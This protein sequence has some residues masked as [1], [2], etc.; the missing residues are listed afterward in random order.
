[1]ASGQAS[2]Q[3]AQGFLFLRGEGGQ[4]LPVDLAGG[5]QAGLEFGASG[6]TEADQQAPA[7]VRIGAALDQSPFVQAFD[8][9][10][11]GR[12]VHGGESAELVLRAGS[13]LAEADQGGPLGGGQAVADA[14]GEQRRIA[15]VGLAQDE[16]DLVVEAVRGV[17][18]H[19]G[20]RWWREGFILAHGRYQ[21]ASR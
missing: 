19:A 10:L 4:G 8:D 7:V 15:L 16:A 9:A 1:M 3:P 14:I 5:R 18:G 17:T 20:H 6:R 2:E 13:G 12:G 11:D 21:S